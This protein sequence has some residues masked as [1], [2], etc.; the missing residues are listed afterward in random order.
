METKEVRGAKVL[1]PSGDET[2]VSSWPFGTPLEGEKIT[3]AEFR[4][5]D[6]S[7]HRWEKAELSRVVFADS[8]MM[9][10]TTEDVTLSDVLFQGCQFDYATLS[11]LR[12]KGSVAFVNCRFREAIFTGGDL[13]STVFDDC[14]LSGVEFDSVKMTGTDIRECE[15]SGISGVSSLKG[16]YVAPNQLPELF[17][18]FA[19]DLGLKV[20]EV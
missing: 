5:V 17:D 12:V 16:A 18:A 1:L 13:G 15:V 8:R 9:G 4:G 11:R 10:L 20:S 3:N 19:K 6:L 14:S 2:P 7:S